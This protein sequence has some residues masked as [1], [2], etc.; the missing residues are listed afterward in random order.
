MFVT[1]DQVALVVAQRREESGHLSGIKLSA[2]S[3]GLQRVAK[4][5]RRRKGELCVHGCVQ[6][7]VPFKADTL[8]GGVH[9]TE[10]VFVE[11]LFCTPRCLAFISPRTPLISQEGFHFNSTS[12]HVIIVYML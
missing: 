11:G 9:Y 5:A 12:L 1:H 3:T 10:V 6:W 7:Y 2:L 4:M 8:I